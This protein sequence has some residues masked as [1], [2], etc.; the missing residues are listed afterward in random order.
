MSLFIS[1]CPHCQIDLTMDTQLVGQLVKCPACSNQFS[2]MQP[3]LS[4]PTIQCSTAISE[5]RITTKKSFLLVLGILCLFVWVIPFKILSIS[6]TGLGIIFCSSIFCQCV[7]EKY[8]AGIV[9]S[10]SGLTFLII[11]FSIPVFW[12][13]IEKLF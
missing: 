10:F 9:L 12:N 7:K 8:I 4:T 5:K 11:K 6:T 3:A 13:I 2:V 1:K